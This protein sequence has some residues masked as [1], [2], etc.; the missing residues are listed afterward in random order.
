MIPGSTYQGQDQGPSG[1]QFQAESKDLPNAGIYVSYIVSYNLIPLAMVGNPEPSDGGR[2]S[3]VPKNREK[4]VARITASQ[5]V[6]ST[7]PVC[8]PKPQA[9][10]AVLPGSKDQSLVVGGQVGHVGRVSRVSGIGRVGRINRVGQV[11]R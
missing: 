11:S 9:V 5:L 8:M 10:L 4:H 6:E 3:K 7:A 2:T 1:G